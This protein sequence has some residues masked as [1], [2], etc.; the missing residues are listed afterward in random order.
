VSLMPVSRAQG[1]NT[2]MVSVDDQRARD[3]SHADRLASAPFVLHVL[4]H[5][6]PVLSGYSIRSRNLI[7]AQ[8]RLGE[9]I[10]VVT[11][12]LH[13]LDDPTA[14]DV[15]LDGVQYTRTPIQGHIANTVLRRRWPIARE[16][17]VVRMLRERLLEIIAS[18]PVRLLYAHSPALCGLAALQA[19]R[20]SGLPFVYE[21]RAFWEDAAAD[22]NGIGSKPW[23]SRLT[24]KLETYVAQRADAVAAIAKPM[25]RDLHLRGIPTDRL[26]H[27][28]NGVDIDWFPPAVRDEGL[29]QELNLGEGPV[30]GF[31]GSLYRYEGVSWMIRAAAQLHSRGHKFCIL[32]I[33]RG[34]DQAAIRDVI[35]DCH[36]AAYVRMIDHVPHEQIGRYYSVIDVAV[37]PRRSIRLTEL[38]TPLKPLEAMALMKPV[39]ASGVGGIRE[40]VENERTGLLF[41]ADDEADFC[42]QAERMIVSPS[43]RNSLAEQGR[44]FVLRE[45]D[46]KV[47]A[48]RYRQIYDFVLAGRRVSAHS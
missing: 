45:R 21:I 48:E 41:Q 29:A 25:L 36:A 15:T 40:L 22:R 6:W 13:Q 37:Y 20:K 14:T 44:E 4:D 32:I 8:H 12:P 5:S 2:G 43:L 19:A 28:P 33:G 9:A 1:A 42:R 27:V 24:H 30:L 16:R 38:V 47:L 35:R 18:Q 3:S 7:T 34:E 31:F 39:L 10:K 23:R 17:E 26:F 11:S 46:W